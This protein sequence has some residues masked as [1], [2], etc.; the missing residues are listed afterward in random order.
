V[1]RDNEV[2]SAIIPGNRLQN[3]SGTFH[4]ECFYEILHTLYDRGEYLGSPQY[5]KWEVTQVQT[6]DNIGSYSSRLSRFFLLSPCDVSL[7]GKRD[8]YKWIRKARELNEVL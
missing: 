2:N 5:S 3:L 7:G 6:T 8:N 1:L 4:T